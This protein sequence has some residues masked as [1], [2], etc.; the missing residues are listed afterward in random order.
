MRLLAGV[1]CLRQKEGQ[2]AGQA[3]AVPL[4]TSLLLTRNKI[5]L[6]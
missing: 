3:A 5:N 4:R 6:S 2:T 1:F